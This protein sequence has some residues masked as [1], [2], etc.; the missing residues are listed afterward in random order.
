MDIN[1]PVFATIAAPILALFI[2]AALNRIVERKPRIIYYL[3]QVSTFRLSTPQQ[4]VLFTHSIVVVNNGKKSAKGVRIGHN[5]L[6]D[7]F[8]IYPSVNYEIETLPSGEKD[9]KIPTMVP[10]EQITISYLYFPPLTLDRIN[11]SIKH[12]DGFA[13]RLYVLPTPQ[14]PKWM[15][16]ILQ[17]FVWLGVIAFIYIAFEFVSRFV[18]VV[19]LTG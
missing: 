17:F 3:G 16:R 2:G 18:K 1:W 7:N 5:V 11:S 8:N 15:I 10:G 12:D 6:P 19:F 14:F 13:K 4:F 9:I